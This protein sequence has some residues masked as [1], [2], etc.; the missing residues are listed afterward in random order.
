MKKTAVCSIGEYCEALSG[1]Q[2]VPGGGSVNAVYGAVGCSLGLMV[3]A[4]TLGKKKYE[5]YLQFSDQNAIKG[6]IRTAMHYGV[7]DDVATLAKYVPV[8]SL[9]FKVAEC[10]MYAYVAL[11]DVESAKALITRLREL[12]RMTGLELNKLDFVS[13]LAGEKDEK[14]VFKKIASLPPRRSWSSRR[15]IPSPEQVGKPAARR[16][17]G[18]PARSR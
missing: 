18:V 9:D 17:P 6:R 3:I 8:D 5:K 16:W 15:W 11:N 14:G 13:R 1:R 10:T 2:P 4:Y 7:F 12:D